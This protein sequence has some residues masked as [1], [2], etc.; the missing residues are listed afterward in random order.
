[1]PLSLRSWHS[2]VRRKWTTQRLER[3]RRMD[4]IQLDIFISGCMNSVGEREEVKNH[5]HSTNS[6]LLLEIL[7]LC[8]TNLILLEILILTVFSVNKIC[9]Q[10]TAI[11]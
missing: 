11:L 7:I 10:K 5:K 3:N 8:N 6:I 9:P 4:L 1:M 2:K